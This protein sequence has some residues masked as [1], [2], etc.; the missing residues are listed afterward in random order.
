VKMFIWLGG[1]VPP[2]EP[3][4]LVGESAQREEEGRKV[5]ELLWPFKKGWMRGE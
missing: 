1:G 4:D 2:E 3:P 5:S